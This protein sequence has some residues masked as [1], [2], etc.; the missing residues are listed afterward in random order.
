MSANSSIS[1]ISGS[2]STILFSL[3]MGHRISSFFAY[4]AA[5][6]FKLNMDGCYIAESKGLFYYLTNIKQRDKMAEKQMNV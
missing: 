3:I 4:V 2:A 1:V 5:F 6:Y